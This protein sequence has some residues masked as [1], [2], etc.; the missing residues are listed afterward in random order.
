MRVATTEPRGTVRRD[1][2]FPPLLSGPAGTALVRRA[3]SVVV[4]VTLDLTACFAGIY[5]ALAF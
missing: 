1:A 5:A 3:L 2:R 4:L